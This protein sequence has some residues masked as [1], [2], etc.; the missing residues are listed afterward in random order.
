MFVLPSVITLAPIPPKYV[1]LHFF[2]LY[3]AL[4]GFLPRGI[5]AVADN[6]V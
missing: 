4:Y 2:Y 3:E 5:I 6:V 1:D